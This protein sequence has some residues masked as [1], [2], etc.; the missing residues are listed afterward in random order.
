MDRTLR[1]VHGRNIT[2]VRLYELCAKCVQTVSVQVYTNPVNYTSVYKTV[3]KL[4]GININ[5]LKDDKRKQNP[6]DMAEQ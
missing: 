2:K 3:R 6:V 4:V 1:N 5:K